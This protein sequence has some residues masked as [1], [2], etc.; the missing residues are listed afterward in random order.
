MISRLALV[1]T[2]NDSETRKNLLHLALVH[3]DLDHL[4]LVTT[5]GGVGRGPRS[6]DEALGIGRRSRRNI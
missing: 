1:E 3:A 4:D 6:G 5:E 2:I